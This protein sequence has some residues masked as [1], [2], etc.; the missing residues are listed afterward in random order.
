MAKKQSP[1]E[2]QKKTPKKSTKQPV[3]KSTKETTPP[4]VKPKKVIS[5]EA[6][7]K[8]ADR[9]KQLADK[10]LAKLTR[11]SQRELKLNKL[12]YTDKGLK[13]F[14]KTNV[15]PVFRGLN[16]RD[17]RVK[18]IRE[19]VKESL[20]YGGT[21]LEGIGDTTTQFFNPLFIDIGEYTGI[22]WADLDD[23]LDVDLRA[24][25]DNKPLRVE[26][27]V[28]EYGSTGVFNLQD[29]QYEATGINEIY[30]GIRTVL[31]NDSTPEYNGE[32]M[33]RKGKQDD[34]RADSYILQFTLY[35]NG[36]QIPPTETLDES[37]GIEVPKETQ[38]QRR[39]RLKDII[40]RKKEL[41]AQK[42]KK[43]KEKLMRQRE[44]PKAKEAP[45]TEDKSEALE[46]Q[47][48]VLSVLE[49]QKELIAEAKQNYKDEIYDKAE[50]KE[51][52]K[53]ISAQTDLALSKF[54]RGGEI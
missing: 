13:K 8:L 35:V 47:K 43:Q 34:G 41:A 2:P 21:E 54:R 7:K 23:Y 51:R 25:V 37:K 46:R 50:Y 33:V 1:N 49:Y 22:M 9:K 14:V 53:E 45:A 52:L 3:K 24:V 42:R 11:A 40:A 18:D 27:N 4:K 16:P 44:R 30:E 12:E 28:G 19:L 31:E 17:V 6:K 36:V 39:A 32:V 38:A 20:G 26:V 48:N 10:L 15:L 29:Y 5:P